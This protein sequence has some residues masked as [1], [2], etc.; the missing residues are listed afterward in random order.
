M[1]NLTSPLNI[2]VVDDEPNIRKTLS[3]Y[4]KDRGHQVTLTG[5]VSDAL[6]EAAQ[7]SFDMA[8][9]DLR[10]GTDSGLDLIPKLLAQ[11]PWLKIVVITA[12][13][14]IETAVDAIR[15]GAA[16]YLPKPFT[17]AQLDL[18]IS[19]ISQV[20][21]LE[22]KLASLETALSEVY[23]EVDLSTQ[24]SAMKKCIE[25]AKGAA[26]SEATIL[27]RGESGTGKTVLARAIHAWSRRKDGPFT[28]VSCP[29]LSEQLLQSELFGHVKGAFTDA[30]K[31]NPGL[32][33]ASEGGTLFLDEIGDLPLALQ[34]KLL[35]FLQE[36][37]YERVGDSAVHQADVRV[38]VATNRDLEAMI[39]EGRFREDLFYRLNIVQ[40]DI[41]P[42]RERPEDIKSIAERLLVFFAQ[43]NNRRLT[44]FTQEA[45]KAMNDHAWP[46]NARELRNTV[47]RAAILC[48]QQNVGIEFLPFAKQ[49][50]SKAPAL[51]EKI[52]LEKLE[53][54][55]I[56][57]LIAVTA[58]LEEAARVLGID[59]ATLWRKR[60]EYML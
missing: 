31:D 13:A 20:R 22:K 42:L 1:P 21:A 6:S 34:P 30:F 26:D 46:G 12:F 35:R 52:S 43:K 36:R 15:K 33:A 27:I 39:K 32:M 17:P 60:K 53:K 25:L 47:E 51:G 50:P 49:A 59:Q 3:I 41:P 2:L 58:S 11:N 55:H 48:R 44:G 18:A 57:R 45:M 14:S 38:V 54:E 24:N 10:L 5:N 28:V 40:I 9:L 29:S 16:E 37:R 19:K 56:R 7:K 8:F 23:P 4:C